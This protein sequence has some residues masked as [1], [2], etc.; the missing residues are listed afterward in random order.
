MR[1]T[2]EGYEKVV[3]IILPVSMTKR[4]LYLFGV[5]RSNMRQYL[6]GEVYSLTLLPHTRFNRL[7]GVHRFREPHLF[8]KRDKITDLDR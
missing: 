3:S 8:T 7:A 6:T 1:I 2:R 4:V 5:C